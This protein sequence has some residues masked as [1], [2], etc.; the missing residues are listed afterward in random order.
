MDKLIDGLKAAY[1][2]TIKD[3]T[4]PNTEATGGTRYATGKPGGW[5]YAPIYGLKLVAPVW[6]GGAEKYAP[7]DWA[8]GQSHS[9]LIDCA[10]RHWLEVLLNGVW[11][12]DPES[13]HLHLAHAAWNIL[14]LLTFM[15][16]GREDLDDVTPYRGVNALDHHI[17]N[18]LSAEQGR[19]VAAIL[20]EWHSKDRDWSAM[21]VSF[22]G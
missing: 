17:A 3:E 19:P 22:D 4:P 1:T 5:W 10:Q 12:R 14:C 18:K 6:E 13:G 20:L 21:G 16:L 7:L 9:T 8:E 11:A 2:T 15:A